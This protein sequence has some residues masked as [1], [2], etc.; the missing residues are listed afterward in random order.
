[1]ATI[2][3][4]G[5]IFILFVWF[6]A[7]AQEKKSNHFFCGHDIVLEYNDS[8]FPGYKQAVAKT[9]ADAKLK[10]L[11]K[12]N[13]HFRSNVYTIPVVVH[14]VWRNPEENIDDSVVYDQIRRLNEDFRRLNEDASNIREIYVDRQADALIEFEL[15]E[16]KRVQTSATFTPLIITLPDNVKRTS[17]GGSDAAD[18][19]RHMNIWVCKIQP[20]PFIGGQ[21]F[22]YAYPPAGLPNWP[23]GVAAPS[24]EL[25]GVVVDFR[26]FGS[27]NPNPMNVPGFGN[28][29]QNGRTVTHEVGHYLGLRH[30]WGDGGG[31]F[32]GSS[33][34]ADDGVDD[35][36]NQGASSNYNC[37]PNQNTCE[38]EEELDMVEN[39]M[40]YSDQECQN[41]FTYGQVAIMRAVLEGPRFGLISQS[42]ST[43]N[44]ILDKN[45]SVF[46]NPGSGLFKLHL[47]SPSKGSQIDVFNLAG[48]CVLQKSISPGAFEV[49]IDLHA[50]SNGF[51]I[52]RYEG[53]LEKI[54]LFR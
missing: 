5:I 13:S 54:L 28:I 24:P 9:F 15:V 45:F 27:N 39:Y 29:L 30:I 18:V 14:I 19:E 21:V 37:D 48:Q 32:G 33:C 16:I 53:S 44:T 41:T 43:E 12:D 31:I 1:M 34:N 25:D 50:L 11:D 26:C 40:D 36:P 10:S 47:Q 7:V 17:Q 3:H 23:E 4:L 38:E 35:T 2:K 42:S 51:Y 52:I 49:E 20:I 22:G 8:Y 6:H 46:P